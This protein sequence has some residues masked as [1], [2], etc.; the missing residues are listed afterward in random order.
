MNIS[1]LTKFYLSVILFSI[2]Y[3]RSERLAQMGTDTQTLNYSLII[4]TGLEIRPV[5]PSLKKLAY[6]CMRESGES[7]KTLVG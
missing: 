7:N 3:R 6:E 2:Y 5:P 1:F 4:T